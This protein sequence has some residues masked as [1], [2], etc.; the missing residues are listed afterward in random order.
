[1]N[2]NT[3]DVV[4]LMYIP[5]KNKLS[6]IINVKYYRVFC[7]MCTANELEYKGTR[8]LRKVFFPLHHP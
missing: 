2:D 4:L 3:P 8:E 7:I 5:P 1:M 6:N